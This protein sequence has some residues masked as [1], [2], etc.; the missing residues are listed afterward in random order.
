MNSRMNVQAYLNNV[1][2][3]KNMEEL[4]HYADQFDV[5]VLMCS[6]WVE[7][8][9]PKWT[10]PGDIVLFFHAKTAIQSIRRLET[11]LKKRKRT[12]IARRVSEALESVAAGTL[13]LPKVRW[14]NIGNWQSCRATVLR[15]TFRH[16]RGRETATECEL[17]NKP[18]DLCENR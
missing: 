14:K 8:T 10:V 15:C 11:A 1:S 5:E 6:E 9:V 2:F 18:Q 12:S 3:P 4:D 7:W 13:A 17:H 16:E